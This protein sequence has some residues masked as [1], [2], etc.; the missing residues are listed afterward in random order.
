MESNFDKAKIGLLPLYLMPTSKSSLINL[1]QLS[2][3]NIELLFSESLGLKSK[4]TL[5]L[6]QQ[7]ANVGKTAALLF[8][9]PSTRTRFS[10]EA[11]CVRAGYHPMILDGAHGTSLEK[12]ESILD[13]VLNIEAMR[14]SFFIIRADHALDLN[15]LANQISVPL[16][17]AGWGSHGHPTQA[18]LDGLTLF[19]KWETLQNKKILFIGDIRHSRVVASHFELAKILGY[20]IGIC[21]PAEFLPKQ[22]IENNSFQYFKTLNQGLSWADAVMALRVQKERHLADSASEILNYSQHYGLNLSNI[23]QLHEKAWILHPG[24]INYGIEMESEILLDP[25]SLIL[26]QVENGVFLREALIR[27]ISKE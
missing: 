7:N 22:N 5:N 9:E 12:G 19:E 20:Q 24:P 16:I 15:Q 18:L 26:K 17:N 14:P 27:N 2:K 23:K 10:F 25:R 13:T 6:G 8:F 4:N 11:A 21:A 3:K 1:S